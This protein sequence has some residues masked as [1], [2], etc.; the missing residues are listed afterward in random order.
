MN[1]SRNSHR[2]VTPAGHDRA[3]C[4]GRVLLTPPASGGREAVFVTSHISGGSV[5]N[6]VTVAPYPE[7]PCFSTDTTAWTS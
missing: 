5:L 7:M 3:A 2:F 6:H 4:C 1:V